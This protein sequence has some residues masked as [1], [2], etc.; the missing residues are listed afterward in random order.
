MNA[1]ED[2]DVV[3]AEATLAADPF[4]AEHV[5]RV[6]ASYRSILTP[7]A[8]RHFRATLVYAYTTEPAFVAMVRALRP[9]APVIKSGE[10]P[11]EGAGADDDDAQKKP[12]GGSK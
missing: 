2:P 3:D 12:V 9:R 6:M 7:F 5:E 8:F 1:D 11:I 10:E 4:L